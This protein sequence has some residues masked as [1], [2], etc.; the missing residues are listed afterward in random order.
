VL[1]NP[2]AER[3]T[4]LIDG[5]HRILRSRP[6]LAVVPV[7]RAILLEASALRASLRSKLPDAIH[8]ATARQSGCRRFLTEDTDL[9]VPPSMEKI[10]LRDARFPL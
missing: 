10:A 5:Y 3:K 1:P 9:K 6:E 7:T 2:I 8:V 4:K